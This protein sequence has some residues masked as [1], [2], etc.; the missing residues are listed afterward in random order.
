MPPSI[1]RGARS[2]TA[3]TG[4]IGGT[5]S[6]ALN[7]YTGALT[8]A[9]WVKVSTLDT[10]LNFSP[11]DVTGSTNRGWFIATSGM[12]ATTN[13]G[14]DINGGSLLASGN[15]LSVNAWHHL[16][17]VY[18]GSGSFA[19]YQDGSFVT[20]VSGT[21]GAVNTGDFQGVSVNTLAGLCA[22][23]AVWKSA[24]SAGNITSL[25]NGVRPINVGSGLYA[26]YPQDG[27]SNS[28][29]L[30]QSG[31]GNNASVTA[32]VPILGPPAIWRLG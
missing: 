8:M 17:A 6:A 16:A 12:G 22:D 10:T 31:N 15:N 1:S 4:F 9:A 30:D 27:F 3:S 28:T 13:W 11:M 23:S 25:W 7:G 5:V 19:L 29:E 26:W 14:V 21:P 20:N 2:Y 24:L 32:A 18:N